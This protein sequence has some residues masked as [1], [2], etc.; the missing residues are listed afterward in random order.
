MITTKEINNNL[1]ITCDDCGKKINIGEE[2]WLD[3]ISDPEGVC[4]FIWCLKC[5][6]KL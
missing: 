5:K 2:Y 4:E 3:S 6:E 1:D